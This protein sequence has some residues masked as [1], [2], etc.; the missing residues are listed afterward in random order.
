MVTFKF[1]KKSHRARSVDNGG[2]DKMVNFS[3]LK[4]AAQAQMYDVEHY[5]KIDEH[6]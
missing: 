5:H 4:I 2:F 6:V 3:D 1:W